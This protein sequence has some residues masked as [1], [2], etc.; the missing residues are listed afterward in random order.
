MRSS[1][2]KTGF[3]LSKSDSNNSH[4]V[5]Q[6]YSVVFLISGVRKSEAQVELL[7]M[8]L[9]ISQY[10]IASE[11][12]LSYEALVT[13]SS[14]SVSWSQFL[15]DQSSSLLLLRGPSELA[16]A[17]ILTLAYWRSSRSSQT[18]LSMESNWQKRVLRFLNCYNSQSQESFINTVQ[19]FT[20]NSLCWS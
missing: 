1:C 2:T 14:S 19:L 17:F 18:L 4:S 13:L 20:R 11:Q 7:S 10:Y 16:I 6:H 3:S 5:L 12:F 8:S 15:L 9:R